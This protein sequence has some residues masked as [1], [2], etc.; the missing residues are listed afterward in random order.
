MLFAELIDIV[1]QNAVLIGIGIAAFLFA[2]IPAW[3]RAL[4][5]SYQAGKD[6]REGRTGEDRKPADGSQPPER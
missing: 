6:W 3:R 2:V 1:E 5:W 4:V